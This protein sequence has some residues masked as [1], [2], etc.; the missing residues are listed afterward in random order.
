MF[1]FLSN[2]TIGGLVLSGSRNKI[3]KKAYAKIN[4]YLDIK[5]RRSDGYHILET[6]MV[7]VSIYDEVEIELKSSSLGITLESCGEFD[8]PC[9]ESNTAFKAASI[10][11]RESKI[12]TGI[13]IKI[14]KNIP[15]EAGLGGGSSDGA[16]VLTGLNS[17]FNDLFSLDFLE[18]KSAEIGADLPFFIRSRPA[19]CT[20]IGNIVSPHPG[21]EKKYL[22]LIHPLKGI[23]TAEVYKKIN[24]GLTNQVKINKRL[25]FRDCLEVKESLFNDLEIVA[26]EMLPEIGSVKTLLKQSGAVITQMSGSGSTCFGIYCDKP[27]RDKGFEYI[28]NAY[29]E[30]W[31]VY[32]SEFVE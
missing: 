18:E 6:L 9:D 23:K 11:L 32:S 5:G 14:K 12:K 7:P 1:P 15:S 21:L 31:K 30:N 16:S 19:V 28:L 8:C 26:E 29:P 25:L 10:F 24:W 22:V 27:A 3:I 2:N 20:G 4:L 13:G 17:L